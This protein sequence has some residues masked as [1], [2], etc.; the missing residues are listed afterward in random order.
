MHA[1][2]RSS[3]LAGILARQDEIGLK[4]GLNLAEKKPPKMAAGA[5]SLGTFIGL[6]QSSD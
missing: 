4:I 6:F 1:S 3:V 5:S 2:S